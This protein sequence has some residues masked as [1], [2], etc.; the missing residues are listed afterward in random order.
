[1]KWLFCL[2]TICF[3]HINFAGAQTKV[4]N[5]VY[6]G[7]EVVP[8]VTMGGGMDRYDNVYLFRPDGTFNDAMEKGDWQTRVTGRYAVSG[9]KISVSYDR[10]KKTSFY[11]I[12]KDGNIDAG[13]YY[14]IKMPVDNSIPAGYY[15]FSKMSSSGGGSGMAYVGVGSD[16]GLNFDGK[17]NFSNSSAS[18]TV[19]AGEGVGGGSSHKSSGAGTYTINRGILI[20]NYNNGK[21]EKHS[22]FCRPSEKPIMA[23]VDGNIYFMKDPKQDNVKARSS[24]GETSA[25]SAAAS[26]SVNGTSANSDAGDA[27]AFLLK[28]NTV[29]GGNIL[30]KVKTVSMTATLEGLQVSTIID[31]PG[32]RVRFEV[33]QNGKLLQVEQKE[34]QNGWIWRNGQTG[35]LPVTRMAELSAVFTSGILGLRKSIIEKFKVVGFKRADA[36]I[37]VICMLNGKKYIFILNNEGRMLASGDNSGKAVTSS[38]YADFRK[39]DGVLVPFKEL[40]TTD[41]RKTTV[42][43]D[44][45]NFNIPLDNSRWTKP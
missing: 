5:G 4:L 36:G 22:F 10:S 41:N 23:V 29:H 21:I 11:K 16:K 20:L 17:G 42:L 9:S 15:E 44:S 38:V 14:L 18:A 33:K 31:V 12:D 19:V 26:T 1:M 37:T 32:E 27:K 7:I 3:L 40:I 2:T 45:L 34:G 39:S 28:A 43:Y 25:G 24:A 30:D 8:G 6:A 13:G 35:A